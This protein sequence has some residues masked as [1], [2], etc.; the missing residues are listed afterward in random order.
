MARPYSQKFLMELFS[1][2]DDSL[3]VR[4]AR[5]CVKANLGTAHVA[6]AFEVSRATIHTWFRGG[7]IKPRRHKLVETFITLVEEDMVAGD[8]PVSNSK[9]SKHYIEEMLGKAI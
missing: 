8:L 9:Q 5:V 4:L 6:A 7:D 3:G 1:K 2:N